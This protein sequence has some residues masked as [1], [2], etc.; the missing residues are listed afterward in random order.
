MG[1]LLLCLL[2]WMAVS[3]TQGNFCNPTLML[4]L[5]FKYKIKILED[6]QRSLLLNVPGIGRFSRLHIFNEDAR[7]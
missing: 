5:F 2:L 4:I 6:P 7:L 3:R 1:E